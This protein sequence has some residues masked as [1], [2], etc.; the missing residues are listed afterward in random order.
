MHLEG[1]GHMIMITI[2]KTLKENFRKFFLISLYI[3][4]FQNCML[5]YTGR[6]DIP[7]SLALVPFPEWEEKSEF[8]NKKYAKSSLALTSDWSPL[9]HSIEKR[10]ESYGLSRVAS[11]EPEHYFIINYR[12]ENISSHSKFQNGING[13]AYLN[14]L[15]FFPRWDTVSYQLDVQEI[16]KGT[17]IKKYSFSINSNDFFSGMIFYFGFLIPGSHESYNQ[18]GIANKTKLNHW[19]LQSLLDDFIKTCLEERANK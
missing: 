11:D 13:L 7:Y 2:R 16:Y 1:N 12:E 14:L 5:R 6:A 3:L 19:I 17:R 4:L 15:I 18:K 10:L 9:K 8:K